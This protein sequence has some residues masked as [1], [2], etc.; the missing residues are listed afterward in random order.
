MN[1]FKGL[2]KTFSLS[3]NF[4]EISCQ[5]YLEMSAGEQPASA[6]CDTGTSGLNDILGGG[7]PSK[8]LYLNSG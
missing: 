4:Q 1:I 6:R 5:N 3:Q 2:D 7:F 8:A